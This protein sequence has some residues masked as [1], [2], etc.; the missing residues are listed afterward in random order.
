MA[1]ILL[2][3]GLVIMVLNRILLV[4][5]LRNMT[6]GMERLRS[7]G[8]SQLTIGTQNKDVAALAAS[9]NTLYRESQEGQAEMIRQNTELKQSM[10]DISHDLRTPLTALIGYL[11]LL[12][13]K[14]AP[15][16]KQK[17]YLDTAYE[18]AG[19]LHRLVST[20]FDLARLESG[21]YQFVWETID[22]KQLLEQE[23]AAFYT[24]FLELGQEPAIDLGE[25]TLWV[26]G[27]QGALQRILGNLIQNALKHGRG[28]I[29]VKAYRHKRNKDIPL[30]EKHSGDKVWVEVSNA[31]P[32]LEGTDLSLLFRR[33]YRADVSRS[34]SGS[35]LGLTIVKEF[36]EQM[37]GRVQAEYREGRIIIILCFPYK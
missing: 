7:T 22:V 26:R 3:A 16:E 21:A 20:L 37:N 19:T 27:D 31:A 32:D 4:R 23:L 2:G 1:A 11:K 36:T 13:Q 33:A 34:G 15:S 25:E 30:E 35:G 8:S 29:E 10:A 28:E 9:I 5:E 18:K 12:Y 17:Q 6:K 24:Q 14:D